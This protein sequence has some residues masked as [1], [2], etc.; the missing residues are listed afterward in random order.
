MVS[1]GALLASALASSAAAGIA[2][3]ADREPITPRDLVEAADISGPVVSPDGKQVVYR[4]ARPSVDANAT[5]LDWYVAEL[6]GGPPRHAASA[7]AARHDGAGSIAEQLVR[8]DPDSR[9]FRYIA[10]AD[11]VASIWHWRADKGAEREI[12]DPAD[13]LDFSVSDDGRRLRYTTGASRAAVA[14]AERRA[15]DEGVLIDDRVDPGQPLAGGKIED[16]RRI[17][18]RWTGNWFDR[19]RILHDAPKQETVV[20]LAH[21]DVPAIA[22]PA[23]GETA[24]RQGRKISLAA[25]GFAAVETDAGRTQ[26][27]VARPDGSRIRCTTGPCGSARLAAIAERPGA[28]WL[29]L[30]ESTGTSAEKIWQWRVGAKRPDYFTTSDGAVRTPIWRDRCAAAPA[31]LVCA[32]SAAA[33]PPRLV[34]IDYRTG[35]RTVLADPNAALRKRIRVAAT[36]LELA[37]GMSGYLLRP[38]QARGPLPAVVQYYR[39]DGFLKGGVGDE[40]PMLP[41]V[42]H[43]ISVLCLNG[44]NAPAEASM[45]ASYE[46]ALE[47]I[48]DAIDDLA[49]KGLI[50]KDHVGIG[51]LSFGSTVAMWAIRKSKRFAAA[52]IASGQFSPFYYWSNAVPDR[53]F[54]KV[55]REYWKI[56]DPEED[57]E[58]WRIISPNWDIAALDTP[59][60]IQAPESELRNLIEL[61]TKLKRAGKPVELFGFAD[62]IH[63][64]YQPVHKHAVYARNLDWY[65]FWLKGEE[66]PAPEKQDRYTRWRALRAGQ[67]LSEPAR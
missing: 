17:M 8:W 25:G 23:F 67:S 19:A 26:V 63:I 49:A 66:D 2:P 9:G 6:A 21:G 1:V 30:F 56:G 43:G 62:E 36:Q 48:G 5:R 47:A 24:S 20:D 18:Q 35:A 29:L 33:S 31:A 41:L 45:Q 57:S 10:L 14:A 52:T 61:H 4:V 11:G 40:I 27:V 34:R 3:A 54:T 65:R 50:D 32:E 16:G 37:N 51:G 13:I 7:G 46:L 39:C 28:N 55:L 12:V 58:R 53:G 42:E 38:P 15:Y 60:L 22:P 59:L 64:K 44:R